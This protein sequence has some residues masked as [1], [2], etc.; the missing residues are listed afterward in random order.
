[1]SEKQVLVQLKAEDVN[2]L[3]MLVNGI[4]GAHVVRI[5]HDLEKED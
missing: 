2:D 3:I 5:Y 4:E 1:M